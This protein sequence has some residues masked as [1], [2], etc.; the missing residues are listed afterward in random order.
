MIHSEVLI[1]KN[2]KKMNVDQIKMKPGKTIEYKI[3]KKTYEMPFHEIK[4]ILSQQEQEQEK[5]NSSH[6]SDPNKLNKTKSDLLSETLPSTKGQNSLADASTI[7]TEDPQKSEPFK[8]KP[9]FMMGRTGKIF[10]SIVPGWSPMIV[11]NDTSERNIGLITAISEIL[12]L[13]RGMEYFEKPRK[14]F[15]SEG[16]SSEATLP[17]FASTIVSGTFQTA[18]PIIYFNL[19]ARQQVI[20]SQGHIVDE[21]SFHRN[22]NLYASALL[23]TIAIDI[24][25]SQYFHHNAIPKSIR[26]TNTDG[27]QT[28][29][30]ALTWIF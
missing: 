2:G 4:R 7:A 16:P 22:R 8:N 23:A 28:T 27:G 11:S 13:S 24:G 14:Y 3:G 12:I 18:L 15:S 26:I 30:I 9:N 5:R 19:E 10:Q 29:Q 6:P 17:Y 25:L 1:L 21:A 20:T